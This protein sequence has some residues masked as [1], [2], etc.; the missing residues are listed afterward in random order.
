MFKKQQEVK[1]IEVKEPKFKEGDIIKHKLNQQK[2][3]I[4]KINRYRDGYFGIYYS[5]RD[6]ELNTYLL[7]EEELTK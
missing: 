3:I 2:F 1:I 6:S 5:C 7:T 4:Y